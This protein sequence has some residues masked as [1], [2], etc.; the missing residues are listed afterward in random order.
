MEKL[1]ILEIQ[2]RKMMEMIRHLK[3]EK[4]ELETENKRISEQ[5]LKLEEEN[6]FWEKEKGEIRNRIERILGEIENLPQ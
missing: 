2:I 6:H 1:E 4:S 5:V 3:Q